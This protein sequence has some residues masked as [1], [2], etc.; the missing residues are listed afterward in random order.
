M[1][2]WFKNILISIDQLGNS[3]ANGHPDETISSRVGRNAEQGQR[4]AII[5][6]AG[7][8]IVFAVIAGER[9]HC[10]NAIE[11]QRGNLLRVAVQIED[12]I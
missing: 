8:N 4:G 2:R 9:N 11:V 3:V 6:E 7:I 12:E 10:Q 5:L 1:K